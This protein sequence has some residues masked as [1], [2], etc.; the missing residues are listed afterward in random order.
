[1]IEEDS[2]LL[3]TRERELLPTL[4]FDLRDRASSLPA[5]L[6]RATIPAPASGFL[7]TLKM[8]LSEDNGPLPF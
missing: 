5:M 4:I 1:M 8:T 3:D 6:A 2:S 7:A